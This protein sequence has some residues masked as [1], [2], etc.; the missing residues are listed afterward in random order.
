MGHG[1][2]PRTY[3]RWA[4]YLQNRVALTNHEVKSIHKQLWFRSHHSTHRCRSHS[5]LA[6]VTAAVAFAP[7][8]HYSTPP[9]KTYTVQI[10]PENRT[11]FGYS[12]WIQ[13]Y[14]A[15]L[16][17]KCWLPLKAVTMTSLSSTLPNQG[18]CSS[19]L[20]VCSLSLSLLLSFKR[21]LVCR[22]KAYSATNYESQMRFTSLVVTA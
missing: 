16:N 11:P 10:P 21:L 13:P 22:G 7:L 9:V 15:E 19:T 20:L 2:G 17:I 8:R 12:L 5:P 3:H 6:P 18:C 14:M 1:P 4:G